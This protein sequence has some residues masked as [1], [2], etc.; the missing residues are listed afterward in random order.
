MKSVLIIGASRGIGFECTRQ[1]LAQGY[2]VRAMARSAK[3]ITLRDEN[4]EKCA[5]DARDATQ[6]AAALEDVDAVVQAIG[7]SA[8]PDL[9]V[10]PVS[11]FSESTA[12]LIPQMRG[13]GVERLI[14]VTGFGA[15]DSAARIGCLQRVPFRLILGRAYDDKTRQE[16][17]IRDSGLDWT[18]VRPGVLTRGRRTGTYRVLVEP[19]QW[20]NG[21]ISR[22][23]V[24]DFVVRQID[25]LGFLHKA[26]VLI[27][28]PL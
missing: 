13:A 24:A 18:I 2:R 25:D 14:S 22:A 16:E 28:L 21:L 23:D 6:L 20:R 5:G 10:K 7:V 4:L 19:G 3:R 26:P 15:G 9:L 1:A 12:A 8:G 27:S 17:L 11:L